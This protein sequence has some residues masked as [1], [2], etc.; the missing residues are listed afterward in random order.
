MIMFSRRVT[1]RDF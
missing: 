1:L